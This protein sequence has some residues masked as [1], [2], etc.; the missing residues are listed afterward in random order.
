MAGYRIISADNHVIETPDLWTER[1]EPRFKEAAPRIVREDGYDWWYCNGRKVIGIGPGAQAGVRLEDPTKLSR[2][3][4]FDDVRLGGY[5]PEEHIKDMD[6]DDIDVSIVYPTVGLLLYSEPNSEL[7]SAMFR[8][9][10]DWVA[11]F[12]RPYPNKLLAAGLINTDDIPSAIKE[13]ERCANIGLIGALISA[14][15]PQARSYD[16]TEYHP[17]WAAAQDLRM[18]LSLHT[19]TNRP[20]PDQQLGNIDEVKPHYVCNKDHWIRVSLSQMIFGGVFQRYPNLYVGSVENE[21]AWAPYFI[22]RLD[23]TYTDRASDMFEDYW[24][25]YTGEM[26]PSEYFHRNVFMGFQDDAIG[27]KFRDLIGVDNIQWG[28]D[29]PHQESTFPKSRQILEEILVDCS[30]EERAKIAG[31]N[32]ARVYR[33]D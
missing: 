4:V 19:S 8:V 28:S 16:S 26:L 3:G 5:I 6:T 11:E 33:I 25:R 29:Y 1:I 22:E 14:Y 7:L 17:F 13:L 23:Y 21:L 30:E 31:G 20:G 18:P 27:I 10:N 12:C 9:Y 2:K 24:Q 32:A 15:P